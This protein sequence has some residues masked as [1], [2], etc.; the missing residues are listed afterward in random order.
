MNKP[1]QSS[2]FYKAL[3]KLPLFNSD[4]YLHFVNVSKTAQACAFAAMQVISRSWNEDT[5]EHSGKDAA[6]ILSIRLN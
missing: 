4:E 1:L 5:L 6:P 3:I 2:Q